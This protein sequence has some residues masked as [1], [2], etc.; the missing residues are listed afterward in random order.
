MK[1]NG[2]TLAEVLITLS[3]VGI[4]AALTLPTLLTNIVAAQIGPKLTKA[5]SIFEQ[6]TSSLLT[7]RFADSLTDAIS[8]DR[9]SA[10]SPSKIGEELSNYIKM[11]IL[12]EGGPYQENIDSVYYAVKDGIIYEFTGGYYNQ[13]EETVPYR[14]MLGELV[15]HTGGNNSRNDEGRD[16]FHFTLWNDGSLRAKGSQNWGGDD[17]WTLHCPKGKVPTDY[18][19]CAGHI[20]E[21]NFKVLYKF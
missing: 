20:F 15:I 6:A 19:Y 1:K 13:T 2:F 10:I 21:N 7:D 18:T 14:Q 12:R 9:D 8:S 16:K 3:I 11:N 5:V 17:S 4:L